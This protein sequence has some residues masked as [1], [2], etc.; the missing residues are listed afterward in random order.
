MR[1]LTT[2][3]IAA[4][5]ALFGISAAQV[6]DAEAGI[7]C[8]GRYQVVQGRLLA[9]PYCGDAMLGKVARQAGM[10]VS[11]NALR[12]NEGAKEDACRLVGTDIRISDVCSNYMPDG[13]R[14]R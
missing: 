2:T 11:D 5:V 10:K 8:Q 9:T 7:K 4:G 12:W 3:I 13:G 6:G 14:R 1:L